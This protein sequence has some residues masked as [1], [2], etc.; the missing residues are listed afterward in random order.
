M[1]P[2]WHNYRLGP[3]QDIYEAT[4]GLTIKPFPNDQWGST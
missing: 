4:V 2:R 1:D 3:V